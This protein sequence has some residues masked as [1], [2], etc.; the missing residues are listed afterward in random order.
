MTHLHSPLYPDFYSSKITCTWFISANENGY[1]IVRI[2]EIDIW[3][4]DYLAIGFS[5]NITAATTT[6]ILDWVYPPSTISI[7]NRKMWI[8]FRANED[9]FA[10]SG[11][12]LEVARTSNPA[13]CDETEFQCASGYGCLDQSLTCNAY[14]QCADESDENNC[15]FCGPSSISLETTKNATIRSKP[16]YPYHYPS[17]LE[18]A[19]YVQATTNGYIVITF[20]SFHLETN[21]DFFSVGYGHIISHDTMVLKLSG[22]AAPKTITL[23]TTEIWMQWITDEIPLWRGFVIQL[24][25]REQFVPCITDDE[26]QC[27]SGYGC[28]DKALVCDNHPQC[29]DESDEFGCN[30]CGD[31]RFALT[32]DV[33]DNL[34]SPN[35]PK[36][37]PVN[38][39]C[40]WTVTAEFG[41][42]T[43]TFVDVSLQER[44]DFVK[45][46]NLDKTIIE[47]TGDNLY[48][49]PH[50]ITVNGTTAKITFLSWQYTYERYRGF[51]L[52]LTWSP[53]NYTC[54]TDDFRCDHNEL[55]TVCLHSYQRCDG[56]ILCPDKSDEEACGECGTRNI[57]L[58]SADN[59][60]IMLQSP[61]YPL[62][63]RD[64]LVCEWQIIATGQRKILIEIKDFEMEYGYDFLKIG[65]GSNSANA[66]SLLTKM[67]GY[68]NK[69]RSVSS[70]G[71]AMWI[72]MATDATGSYA[73]FELW[74]YSQ[75]QASCSHNEFDCMSSGLCVATEAQCDGFNDCQNFAEE[76]E[77]ASITC[78]GAHM[79]DDST[80]VEAKMCVPSSVVCDGNMDCDAGDDE[81]RCDI[82]RCPPECSCAYTAL[83]NLQIT[84]Q[85]SWT[86]D[87]LRNIPLITYSLE[88]TGGNLSILYPGEF[89]QFIYLKTLSLEENSLFDIEAR[90]FDGLA[91][92]EWLDLSHNPIKVVQSNVFEQ[93]T[94]LKELFLMDVP[95]RTISSRAFIGLSHMEF[96]IL[97]TGLDTADQLNIENGAFAGLDSLQ[98]LYVDHHEFCCYFDRSVKCT[99]LEPHSPLFNC[100]SLMENTLLRVSMWILGISAVIG[101]FLVIILRGNQRTSSL[102]NTQNKQRLYITNLA[103]SDFQMGVYMLIIASAD[104][105]YGAD[106]FAHSVE[107]RNGYLCRLAGFLGL[108]SSETS[109]I[110]ITVISVDRFLCIVFPYSDGLKYTVKTAK[111]IVVFIWLF[112]LILA[113]IPISIAGPDSDF[114]DLSDVCIGLPLI[115]RPASFI[116]EDS[117]LDNQ[118]TFD[119]PVPQTSKPAWYF[120]IGIFLGFNL[121]CFAII[122]VCYLTIFIYIRKASQKLNLKKKL[123]DDIKVAT[124]M[125]VVVGTD[126][127]C[128]FPVIIMGLLSQTGA[129][130]IPLEAYVWSV[131]FILPINSSL[132][133]YLYSIATIISDRRN[134]MVS[135]SRNSVV[136]LRGSRDLMQDGK[137][138]N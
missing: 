125:A 56:V 66:S 46:G 8:Q 107:W 103:I 58:G 26:Y 18:C 34:T 52:Y 43:I 94:H 77:C 54:D 55:A 117:G 98:K 84:C 110:F 12:F 87:V 53:H 97:V 69:I 106:Y 116:F 74:I 42:P 135:E 20:I 14:T 82:N 81:T 17:N 108:L 3:T 122:F 72:I 67:T 130:V 133:P 16:D 93:L 38:T 91:M 118:M 105:Y 64:D 39:E 48:S 11:F 88:L 9:T 115:T 44:Y 63:Y 132:N 90:A 85:D 47:V 33:I 127:I 138:S 30:I 111:M 6:N 104:L 62:D 131:V 36:S 41:I 65:E 126:F 2:L 101:N 78:P 71:S 79:C 86:V 35:Y 37:F 29:L 15:D 76:M 28:L 109:V 89:K 137:E 27:H 136:E 121:V 50:S 59:E 75:A 60:I 73:G 1:F 134:K 83:R 114:Y 23:N 51:W 120:S 92:L 99:T 22:V 102:S 25:L 24:N 4:Q 80:E 45:V 31:E 49:G 19:W 95:L 70:S 5:H 21:R 13:I 40:V 7:D 61:G 100:G 96:L 68:N 119:L 112:T 10:R 128:W 32:N 124:R 57:F 129:V 123:H 113:A